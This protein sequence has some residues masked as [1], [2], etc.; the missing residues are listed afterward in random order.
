[1]E[2]PSNIETKDKEAIEIMRDLHLFFISMRII[3]VDA[4][5]KLLKM[6]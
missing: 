6:K 2:K 3:K 5:S 4:I 1:M